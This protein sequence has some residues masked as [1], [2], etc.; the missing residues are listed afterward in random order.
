MMVTSIDQLARSSFES[1]WAEMRDAA[2]LA[3]ERMVERVPGR[4]PL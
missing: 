1:E 2:P 3:V 4:W